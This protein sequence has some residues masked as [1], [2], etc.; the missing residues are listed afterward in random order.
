MF[1]DEQLIEALLYEEEGDA[2]DKKRDQYKFI[3]A[4]DDDKSELLKDLLAFANSWRRSDAFILLGVQEVKGGRDS[5]LGI[6]ELLDDAA[7]QQFVNSKTNKP[8]QFSYRNLSFEG[9]H[10]A[11]IHIPVQRRPVYLKKD[12]GRLKAETVYVRRGS[13]TAIADIDEISTMG[14]ESPFQ[15]GTPDLKISFANPK[16][17]SLLGDRSEGVS[18][19][20]DV[21]KVSEI[22]DYAPKVANL[23]MASVFQTNSN[24]Y[25][26]LVEYTR[27]TKLFIPLYFAVINSGA[28]TAHAVQIELAIDKCEGSVIVGEQREYPS[29]PKSEYNKLF[30][31]NRPLDHVAESHDFKVVD[32]GNQWIVEA[33]AGNVQPK[34]TY[35]IHEP[36]FLGSLNSQQIKINATVF[37]DEL[38][39]PIQQTL[40]VDI[41]SEHR[42]VTLEE[43][44]HLE[45]ERFQ[46]SSEYKR[47]IE[48]AKSRGD[49]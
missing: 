27:L 42:K 46:A 31:L 10:I 4:K 3:E 24:Y 13:S 12:F 28:I 40:A 33:S 29:I 22:P 49:K 23:L 32:L 17:R 1:S 16:A 30:L 43:I 47:Y 36:I 34:A 45:R 5:V 15:H 26:Q 19:A 35:W 25:R 7:L 6:L 39:S 38:H 14:L 9:K 41:R 48:A 11:L 18:L 20:L 2:L 44:I 8:L 37:S 21:P